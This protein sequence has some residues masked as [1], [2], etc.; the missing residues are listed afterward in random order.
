MGP[1]SGFDSDGTGYYTEP[2]ELATYFTVGDASCSSF[3]VWIFGTIHDAEA[4]VD[5]GTCIFCAEGE[6]DVTFH[7]TKKTLQLMK[8]M[9]II[10]KQVTRSSSV[11]PNELEYGLVSLNLLVFL[12]DVI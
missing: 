5:D 8:C 12:L 6:I 4:T 2:Q 3:D 1:N 9:F 11:F 10:K 7:L